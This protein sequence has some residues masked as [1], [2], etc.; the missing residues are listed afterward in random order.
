MLL[1]KQ[2]IQQLY[3]FTRQHYVEHYD[4]QT[5]LVDHLANDIEQIWQNNPKLT[6]E[7]ARDLSFKKFGI[8]GFMDVVEQKQTR[9]TI[10]YF[11]TILKFGK[12]WFKLPKI[13][14][15]LLI[16]YLFFSIQNNATGFYIY[17]GVFIS[18]FIAELII[19]L[20]HRNNLQKEFKKTGK[21]WLFKDV[22]LTQGIAQFSLVLFY[23]FTFITPSNIEEFITMGLFNRLLTATFI[24]ASVLF[25]V[26]S[27]YV[28]PLKADELLAQNYPDYNLKIN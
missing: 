27:L 4:V 24:T 17:N 1:T 23:F 22:L 9:L 19:L 28:I 25:G 2:H 21:K 6:F 26:I 3:T 15:T 7:Q 10:K 20:K 16:G 12:N 11:K 18:L 14:V 5:E 13:L 8:F